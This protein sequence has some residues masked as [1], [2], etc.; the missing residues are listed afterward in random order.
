M[1]SASDGEQTTEPEVIQ[2][3]W[4]LTESCDGK[5]QQHPVPPS[6]AGAMKSEHTRLVI[7]V[8]DDASM[9]LAAMGAFNLWLATLPLRWEEIP[10][11]IRRFPTC[12]IGFPG[13]VVPLPH[14]P[15]PFLFAQHSLKIHRH[16]VL[17]HRFRC[18]ARCGCSGPEHLDQH[19]VCGSPSVWA[20]W[21]K[22]ASNTRSNVVQCTN[23]QLNWNG[24]TRQ[25]FRISVT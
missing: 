12:T 22:N 14:H 10:G 17:V 19:A 15:P 21:A 4:N 3:R 23:I 18:F 25:S 16:E 8:N 24:G 5:R 11:G 9:F 1:K 13:L 20:R 6:V 7:R 2:N